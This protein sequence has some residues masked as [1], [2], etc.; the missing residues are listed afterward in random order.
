M[1][2]RLVF[3][4]E[5]VSEVLRDARDHN[6]HLF[7]NQEKTQAIVCDCEELKGFVQVGTVLANKVNELVAA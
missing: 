4:H 2:T 5:L 3:G 1:Y 7:I 6:A